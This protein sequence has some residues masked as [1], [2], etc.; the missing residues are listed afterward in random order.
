MNAINKEKENTVAAQNKNLLRKAVDEIWNKGNFGILK[1]FV[2]EDFVIHFS[3]PEEDLHG[4]DNVKKFYT[5]LR[6][7]FPDI[8]FKI[9]DQVA[10]EEKVVTH[11]VASGT[12]KG[13]FKGIPATGKKVNFSAMDID[14][15]V[16]G[17]AVECWTNVD[18]LGLLQQLGVIP[19][20]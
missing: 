14:R 20:M 10:E 11:W 17:K 13:E 4:F 7:A 9:I 3:N 18:E 1:N 5:N 12:H 19:E 6:L 16:N 8:Q 15:V 2:T